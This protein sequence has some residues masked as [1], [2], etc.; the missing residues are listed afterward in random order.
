MS[1][2]LPE[3][4]RDILRDDKQSYPTDFEVDALAG[5]KYIYSEAILQELDTQSLKTKIAAR[6]PLLTPSEQKR[7]IT[8][9]K[10]VFLKKKITKDA[11]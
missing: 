5:S 10:L 7:N 11:S 1:F 3:P 6:I 8:S 9:T 4:L 2:L